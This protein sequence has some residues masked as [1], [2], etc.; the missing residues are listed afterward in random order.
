[1]EKE[2]VIMIPVHV[3]DFKKLNEFAESAWIMRDPANQA[4]IQETRKRL[5]QKHNSELLS[6]LEKQQ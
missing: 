5:L 4:Q 6:K 1:M 2:P 3:D